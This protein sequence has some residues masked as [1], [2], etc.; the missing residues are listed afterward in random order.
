M[1]HQLNKGSKE[2]ILWDE[3]R[4]L[5]KETELSLTQKTLDAWSRAVEHTNAVKWRS[6]TPK[7]S[8]AMQANYL[9]TKENFGHKYFEREKPHNLLL[10]KG[11]KGT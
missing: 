5:Q 8:A 2:A 1:P 9:P 3:E 10:G 6:R 11:C 7:C 4:T